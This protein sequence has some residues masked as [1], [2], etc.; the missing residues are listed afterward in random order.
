MSLVTFRG[1]VAG[2]EQEAEVDQS[3]GTYVVRWAG[4]SES[5]RSLTRALEIA[6]HHMGGYLRQ[7][8]GRQKL[9]WGLMVAIRDCGQVVY[10]DYPG[11]PGPGA[12][13]GGVIAR[14][15]REFQEG[16]PPMAALRNAMRIVKACLGTR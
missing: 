13:A 4:S 3:N 7:A 14:I 8:W 9:P 11:F 6:A 15:R 12:G 2:N 10:G 5:A 1:R 16:D